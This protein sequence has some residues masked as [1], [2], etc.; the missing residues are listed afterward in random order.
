MTY[1]YYKTNTWSN[2]TNQISEET[3]KSGNVMQR[4]KTGGLHNYQMVITKQNGKTI[5]IAGSV[6]QEEKLLTVLKKQLTLL[7]NTTQKS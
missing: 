3:K 7:L 2:E 4:K 6:S 1:F 5:K